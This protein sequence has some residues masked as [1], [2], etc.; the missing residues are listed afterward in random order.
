MRECGSGGV[1]NGFPRGAVFDKHT[2][3][4]SPG[5]FAPCQLCAGVHIFNFA[6]DRRCDIFDGLSVFILRT[7]KGLGIA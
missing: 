5:Y 6:D 4:G 3:L 2:I 1:S 7:G